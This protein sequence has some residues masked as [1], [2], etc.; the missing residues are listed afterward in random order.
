M[1]NKIAWDMKRFSE[2]ILKL[3]SIVDNLNNYKNEI[4]LI[5]T[6][7]N[8]GDVEK[9]LKTLNDEIET[10]VGYRIEIMNGIIEYLETKSEVFLEHDQL[11]FR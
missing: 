5:K 11:F 10:N 2:T 8:K 4:Q 1:E 3:K 7:I 6:D 9:V